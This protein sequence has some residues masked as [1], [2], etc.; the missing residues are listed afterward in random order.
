MRHLALPLLAVSAAHADTDSLVKAEEFE[1]LKGQFESLNESFLTTKSTVDKL[2]K[3]K[4][5]GYIQVQWQHADSGGVPTVA[6]GDFFK[7]TTGGTTTANQR[8]LV[9]RGRVKTTYE[10][11]T[12]RYVLQLDVIPSG[13]GIKDAYVTLMEP[14]LKTFSVTGGVFDRPFGHEISYSSSSRESPERS[15]VFQRVFPGERDLG[16]K[17]EANPTERM[18]LLQY[19]NAKAGLFTGMGPTGAE[20]DN[21]RDFIGRAGFQLPFYDL[22]L[23][24]DGG[25]SA[26][27][28]SVRS[29]PDTAFV[30]ADTSMVKK[31]G[32]RFDYFDRKVYGFDLQTYY[33]I[34]VIGD[35]VGGTALRGEY[36]WGTMPGTSSASGPYGTS[37]AALYE[38][39]FSGWYVVLVQNIGNKL[40][41]LIKYDTYDPNTA[42]S[43][44]DIGKSGVN[45]GLADVKFTTLGLGGI[46][47]WDE[48]TKLTLYYD[49][50]TNEEIFAGATS[51]S[52][53]PY[54]KDLKD[55]II[56]ARV[57][58]KF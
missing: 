20:I 33:T 51:A 56:T 52:L 58:V 39:D 21:K 10:T 16:A 13:V 47:H 49:K 30:A 41:G 25:A 2:A 26:Y 37:R 19:F 54:T 12:S 3:I 48:N 38:R 46:F 14:W 36:L 9:R 40:Q 32:S 31:G 50:V 57:Q 11:A 28:G 22:N 7:D 1:T 17:I 6:G 18:G 45:L 8:Y 4:V 5:S 44:S 35:Y 23:S 43:G 29:I 55:N 27:I 53:K 34:P 42:V 24:V 15:R